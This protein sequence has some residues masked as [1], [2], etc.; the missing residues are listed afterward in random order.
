[1]RAL[2]L[3]LA[4]GAQAAIEAARARI[5]DLNV[6]PVPDGDT[7]TNLALTVAAVVETLERPGADDRAGL[8]HEISRAA[9]MGARGNS[10]V[11]LSQIVRGAADSLSQSDELAPALRSASDAAY[12]AVRKP[13]E[14]T[15]LTA[16]RELAEEA[17]AGGDLAAVVARGDDCV[18]RT[19]ELLPVLTEAGVVDAGAAGLVEIVRGIAGVVAGEPLPEAEFEEVAPTVESV[20]QHLS[21]FKYC[22]AFVV[23]GDRLDADEIER[24]LEPLGDSLLVVG[25]PTALKVHVHTDDPGRALSLGCARGTIANVEIANMHAQTLDRERRLLQAVPD[26]A[27]VSCALVAVVSGAGI[28]RLFESLGARVVDGGPTMNPSTYELVAAVEATGA[29][30][31]VLLPNDANVILAAEH[32]A[33]ASPVPAAVVSTVSLQA[34]LAAA[35]AFDPDASRAENAAAME[36][37]AADVGTGAVTVASRDVQLNGVSI[38]KGAWLGLADG[39]PVAGGETFDEVA[40]AV[41]GRLLE[42]PRTILTFLTGESPE[43]LNGLLDELAGSHPELELEVHDGGQPHYALLI[44]A[45]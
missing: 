11:I 26:A 19:R 31:A 14:G 20:H 17:E 44:G 8:A 41:V 43:P 18:L 5:D 13:V 25:D 6:Y 45:E 21:E 27:D 40:R 4:R 35:V 2:V 10:G 1:M 22:T 7:G 34:G 39:A 24:E 30:E 3:E 12:R 38:R 28:R 9:L 32:A 15:M 23:E 42:R 33:D 37:A 16:I 36:L 29:H